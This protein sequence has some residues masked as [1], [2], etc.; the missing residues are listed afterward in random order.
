MEAGISETRSALVHVSQA[1][2]AVAVSGV[3]AVAVDIAVAAFHAHARTQADPLRHFI[4]ST[5]SSWVASAFSLDHLSALGATFA[6]ERGKLLPRS[7]STPSLFTGF[8]ICADA[9][10]PCLTVSMLRGTSV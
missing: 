9:V 5:S 2:P 1:T 7:Y 4:G 3:Y 6:Q 8:F 10:S